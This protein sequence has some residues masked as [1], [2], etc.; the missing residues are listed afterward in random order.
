MSD[1][2]HYHMIVA[3][4]LWASL[5]PRLCLTFCCLQNRKVGRARGLSPC[6]HDVI[7]K[8]QQ[9]L[10]ATGNVFLYCSTNYAVNA[11]CV[12]QSSPAQ[13]CQLSRILRETQAFRLNLTLTCIITSI[14]RAKHAVYYICNLHAPW[15][16]TELGWGNQCPHATAD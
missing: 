10:E 2:C 12:R 14:S 8:W 15:S 9:F 13:S 11:W 6:E 1:N 3:S 5:I 7:G 4:L 16:G